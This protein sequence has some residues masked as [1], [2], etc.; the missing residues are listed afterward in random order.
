MDTKPPLKK[1]NKGPRYVPPEEDVECGLLGIYPQWLQRF[2]HMKMFMFLFV[3]LGVF[4][5]KYYLPTMM[6]YPVR[7]RSR[8]DMPVHQNTPINMK[9]F[10]HGN[11]LQRERT[12]VGGKTIRFYE[13]KNGHNISYGRCVNI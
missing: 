4:H 10:R 13:F 7:L 9:I 11:K 5:G 12:T 8:S 3:L 6:H 1:S 2:N